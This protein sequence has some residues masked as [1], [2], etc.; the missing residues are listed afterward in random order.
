MLEL[1][2]RDAIGTVLLPSAWG[3]E[4][5]VVIRPWRSYLCDQIIPRCLIGFGKRI[6]S[7]GL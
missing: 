7:C 6:E 5:E 2:C 3:L 1:V 4:Y